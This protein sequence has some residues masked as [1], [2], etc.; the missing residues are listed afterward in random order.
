MAAV[1]WVVVIAI[2]LDL[3]VLALYRRLLRWRLT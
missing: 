1:L 3:V 2:V